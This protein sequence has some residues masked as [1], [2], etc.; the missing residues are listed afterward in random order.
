LQ[1]RHHLSITARAVKLC[2]AII[3]QNLS[4]QNIKHHVTKLDF[5]SAC[6]IAFMEGLT[7]V[8]KEEFSM[9]LTYR[10]AIEST[11]IKNIKIIHLHWAQ[12]LIVQ[13]QDGDT[14]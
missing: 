1:N 11:K 7:L 6:S 9:R 5:E 3:L 4:K 8:Q 13:L 12:N 14:D 2:T 10:S